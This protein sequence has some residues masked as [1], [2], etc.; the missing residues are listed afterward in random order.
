MPARSSQIYLGGAGL[1]LL[2]MFLPSIVLAW[3]LSEESDPDD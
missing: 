1:L 3:T 2:A